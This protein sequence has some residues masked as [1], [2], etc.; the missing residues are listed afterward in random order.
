MNSDTERSIKQI[1]AS[2]YWRRGLTLGEGGWGEVYRFAQNW[3]RYTLYNLD[4]HTEMPVDEIIA[5]DDHTAIKAFSELFHLG[6]FSHEIYKVETKH[7]LIVEN[8]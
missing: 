6:E 1:K 4:E 3:N 2:G 5:K 7:T 8:L